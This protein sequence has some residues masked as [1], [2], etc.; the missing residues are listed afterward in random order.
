MTPRILISG[1]E[2]SRINYERAVTAAGGEAISYY[3]PAA[4]IG[5]DGLLLCGGGD[6]HPSSFG[7][8]NCGSTEIDHRRDIAE[9]A[10]VAAYCAAGKP[11]LG[12]CRGQQVLNVAMGG[13][14]IQDLG[15]P[16]SQFHQQQGCDAVH[17]LRCAP[18]SLLHQIYGSLLFP[19]NSCH[20]QALGELGEGLCA[21]QWSESGIIEGICHRTLPILGVQW[22]PE[23]MTGEKRRLDTINGGK[24]FDWFIQ[25]C[26]D[27]V[28]YGR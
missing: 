13:T 16:L 24:L 5:Y 6:L 27:E 23:R 10:L 12:I 15:D 22:H 3:C 4:D 28:C 1:G 9:L 18:D 14:L 2:G 11:I 20:H 21:I 17:F 8:E 26:S 25:I 19:V 7:Q